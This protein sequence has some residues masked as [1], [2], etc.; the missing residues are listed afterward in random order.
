MSDNKE[1]AGKEK[2][3]RNWAM[4]C[5][6]SGLAG[7]VGIPFGNIIAPL[8]VWLMKKDEFPLV[9]TEGMKALNFQISVTIYAIVAGLTLLVLVGFLLVPAVVI[10]WLVYTIIGAVKTSNGEPFEYPLTIKFFK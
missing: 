4:A 8:V 9:N 2:E 1:S 5:H 3:A 10:F 6:L 7:F